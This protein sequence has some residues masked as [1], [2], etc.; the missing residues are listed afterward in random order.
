MVTD[1][2][3]TRTVESAL[4]GTISVP[5]DKIYFFKKGIPGLERQTEFAFLDVEEYSPLVW[6]VSMD[7]TCHF[8]VYPIARIEPQEIDELSATVYLPQLKQYLD[9]RPQL[10]SYVIVKLAAP[11]VRFNLKAPVLLD[12]DAL[13]GH[14][15]ILDRFQIPVQPPTA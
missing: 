12:P 3:Q 5:E 9:E 13:L 6:M 14:Q 2:L 11:A 4:F 10:V 1:D 15:L 8:P 7:G